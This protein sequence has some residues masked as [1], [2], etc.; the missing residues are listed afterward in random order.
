MRLK[1]LQARWS[2]ASVKAT[3]NR[4]TIGHYLSD[5]TWP[6]DDQ[7]V[8]IIPRSL[9]RYRALMKAFRTKDPP[10]NDENYKFV[11]SFIINCLE[12]YVLFGRAGM[13]QQ[14]QLG[15]G[16]YRTRTHHSRFR[17]FTL[18][19]FL[20]RSG[21]KCGLVGTTKFKTSDRY[22]M[23]GLCLSEAARTLIKDYMEVVRY[24]VLSKKCV[25]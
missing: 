5:E 9:K 8:S 25:A 16:R 13:W 2:S 15:H 11:L 17:L 20:C 12:I 23:Q 14:L 6:E 19:I 10:L 21:V 22:A 4:S 18:M 1:E 3:R 7:V 24:C